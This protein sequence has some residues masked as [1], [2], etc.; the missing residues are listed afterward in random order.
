M[1][2]LYEEAFLLAIIMMMI[3]A[4]DETDC[5]YQYGWRSDDFIIENVDE[6]E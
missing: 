3:K 1:L 2:L 4:G 6:Q 5:N